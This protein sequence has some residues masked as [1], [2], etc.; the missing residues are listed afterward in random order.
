MSGHA[1]SVRDLTKSFDGTTVLDGV[2]LDVHAGEVT[3]LMGENGSGKTIL[4]SCIAD[5]LHPTSG[6]VTVFGESPAE[7]RSNQSFMLQG[8]LLFPDLSGR[9]N[10][11][12]YTELHPRATDE[13]EAIAERF[14]IA[15]S[16]DDPVSEYSGGMVRKLELAVTFG[17]DVPLY[18][19]DEPTAELDLS[20]IDLVHALIEERRQEGKTIVLSSHMPADIQIAE[21]IAFVRNGRIATTGAPE[22]LLETVPRVALARTRTVAEELREFVVE[23]QLFLSHEG[24]RGFLRGDVTEDRLPAEVSLADPSWTDLFN[25]Y[26]TVEQSVR[27]RASSIRQAQR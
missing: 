26:A 8:G 2:D 14:G 16:L 27:D 21:R 20:A 4:L 15:D 17:V 22:A 9:E 7:A 1:I 13:W 11:A 3:L 5:G 25:Y 6:S 18:L 12:F 10:G 23:D 19:L 24:R